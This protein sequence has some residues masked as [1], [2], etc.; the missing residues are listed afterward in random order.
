MNILAIDL[1]DTTGFAVVQTGLSLHGAFTLG[2][3]FPAYH[4]CL[5]VDLVVIERPAYV[6]PPAVQQRYSDAIAYY[7]HL[8]RGKEIRLVRPADWM[9]R[10]MHYP[11][12]ERGVLRTQHE[13]D[14]YRMARWAQDKYGGQQ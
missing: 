1:G 2:E 8:F 4:L 14:A 7:R 3:A 13:K 10:F 5:D 12:P 11:L 6:G 9:P